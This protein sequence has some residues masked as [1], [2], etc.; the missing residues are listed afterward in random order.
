MRD[1]NVNVRGYTDSWQSTN[2]GTQLLSRRWDPVNNKTYMKVKASSV[3]CSIAANKMVFFEAT[4]SI[5]IASPVATT[6]N[7]HR[8]AGLA[9]AAN[10]TSAYYGVVQ[11]FGVASA[12]FVASAA[13]TIGDALSVQVAS[14]TGMLQPSNY[15]D[16][17][18]QSNPIAFALTAMTASVSGC[19]LVLLMLDEVQ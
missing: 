5:G 14:T 9:L 7:I 17:T 6:A 16:A 15:L 19:G 3:S 18:A 13:I 11:R 10:G 4:S 2:D 12:Y 1:I 8:V